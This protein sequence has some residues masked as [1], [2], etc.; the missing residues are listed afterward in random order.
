MQRA[1]LCSCVNWELI[2][3]CTFM[4]VCLHLAFSS[5]VLFRALLCPCRADQGPW[6]DAAS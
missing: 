6:Y 3:G 5:T 4:P 1:M 2:L